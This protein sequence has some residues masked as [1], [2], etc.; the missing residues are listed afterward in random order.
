MS[1]LTEIKQTWKKQ[2]AS[3]ILQLI[4]LVILGFAITWYLADV[5]KPQTDIDIRCEIANLYHPEIN[6]SLKIYLNNKADYGGE[7]FYFYIWNI[8]TNS[9]STDYFVSEHCE[10]ITELGVDVRRFKA[11][12]DFIPPKTEIEFT[13]DSN[14]NEDVIANNS[15][16]VE[17]WGKTTPY[18]K[19]FVNCTRLNN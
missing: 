3:L 17:W 11:I 14:L 4:V 13:L 9:W 2:R 15:I 7:D 1:L 19:E 12:C 16:E 6:Y 10:R 18:K 5:F 8:K